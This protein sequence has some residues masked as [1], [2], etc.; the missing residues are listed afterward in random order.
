M[1]SQRRTDQCTASKEN[2]HLHKSK[3]DVLSQDRFFGYK[4]TKFPSHETQKK[5][6]G[7]TQ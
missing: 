4:K 5:H 3:K 6:G 2:N 7:D 1:E